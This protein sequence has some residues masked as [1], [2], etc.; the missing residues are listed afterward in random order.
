VLASLN[1]PHIASIYGLEESGGRSFLVMELVRG[2]TLAARLA[3]GATPLDDALAIAR[4]IAE[5]LEAAHEK[6]VMHRDLKP[7]NIKVTPAGQVKVLDFGLAKEW[8]RAEV[9]DSNATSQRTAQTRAGII[10]GTPGY[11]SPEQAK[12]LA[13]DHRTD[14][15]AFG[16]LLYEML[17][18]RHAFAGETVAEIMAAVLT[19]EPEWSHLPAATPAA[20]RRVL[21]R[22]LQKDRSRR[23]QNIAD[24]RIEI[25][26]A[27]TEPDVSQPDRTAGTPRK[28]KLAGILGV[29]VIAVAG[30]FA[31]FDFRPP[32]EVPEMRLDITTPSTTNTAA[33]AISP[34]GQKLVFVASGDRQPRLWLRPLASANPQPLAGTEGASYPFW[35]PQNRSVAFF[36]DDSL[37]K[38]EIAGGPPQTLTSAARGRGGTWGPDG[39]IVFA[40]GC[41]LSV[42]GNSS[43]NASITR[44]ANS[45]ATPKR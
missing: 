20:I 27:R 4:Q 6:G 7:A 10:F 1:H 17:T 32:A 23:F 15:F 24:A 2:E 36:A 19:A 30:V 37:K 16:S 29:L 9:K 45:A 35:D 44:K 28:A 33:F 43:R 3:L 12:G 40:I 26:D 18:G 41:C 11:M 31:V 21:R 8:S 22:S 38:V 39:T 25:E 34:D 14:I 42:K 5:A 13:T